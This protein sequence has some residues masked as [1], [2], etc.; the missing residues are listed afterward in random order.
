MPPTSDTVTRAIAD[1]AS[2]ELNAALGKI[3]HCLAQLSNDQIWWRQDESRNSIGNLILHLC[4]NLRQW[5]VVGLTGAPD[6]RDRQSEFS[7]RNPIPTADLLARLEQT[8]CDA[9]QALHSL[10]PEDLLRVRELQTRNVTALGAIFRTI[11]HF[12]GHTQEIIHMTRTILGQSYKFHWIPSPAEQ[13][14]ASS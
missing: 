1:E 5:C 7:H 13:G 8:V 9:S 14:R 12:R 11:P 6:T 10:S 2:S 4:G 3:K